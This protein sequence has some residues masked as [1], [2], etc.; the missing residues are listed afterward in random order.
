MS[1][2]LVLNNY[3]LQHIAIKV[4]SK[5]DLQ[6]LLN[7]QLTCYQW[8]QFIKDNKQIWKSIFLKLSKSPLKADRTEIPCGD[9]NDPYDVIF[10]PIENDQLI[11][12]WSNLTSDILN[13]I[14]VHEIKIFSKHLLK[15]R[16][17]K[18]EWVI[19]WALNIN[20]SGRV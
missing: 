7:C 10:L 19:A 14:S 16:Q 9:P 11:Q 1:L 20:M 17:D 15:I 5:L 2:N 12:A 4:F 8:Y 3:G 6:S 13:S 18:I